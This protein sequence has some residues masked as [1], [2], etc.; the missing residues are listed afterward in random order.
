MEFHR[1]VSH[2][3]CSSIHISWFT[4]SIKQGNVKRNIYSRPLLSH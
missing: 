1:M 2:V 4:V 3:L